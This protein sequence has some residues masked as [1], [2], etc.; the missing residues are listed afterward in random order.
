MI[1][2]E[3][4]QGTPKWLE[5]RKGKMTASNA[6]A[7]ANCGKG[8]KTY[9]RSIMAERYSSGDKEHFSSKDTDR[10]NEYEPVARQIYEFENDVEVEQIGF[11]ELNEYVGCS[12]DGLV[13]ENGG[14]EIKCIND[15]KYFDILLDGEDAIDSDHMWQCQMNLLITGRE[16]WD[17]IYYNPNYPK[18]MCVFRI[19]PDKDAFEQLEKG[20]LKGIEMMD[21]IKS[22]IEK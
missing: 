9:A 1:F 4:E 7:I 18:S 12:P 20:F 6:T 11:I 3:V 15:P 8:L 22:I 2:H 5:V 19:L 17:L 21:E 16:W 13:G 14:T 10:G